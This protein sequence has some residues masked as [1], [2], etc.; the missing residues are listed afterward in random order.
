[1]ARL[2][3]LKISVFTAVF[4]VVALGLAL[5][6]A[7]GGSSNRSGTATVASVSAPAGN[8]SN[9]TAAAKS[10]ASNSS[11]TSVYNATHLGVVSI[12]STSNND[13][14][15]GGGFGGGG[16]RQST[17][18][19]SGILLDNKGDILT[20]EH[21]VDKATK[22][23]VSFDTTPNTTRTA[24]VVGTDPSTDLAVVK[25]DPT[26]LDLKPLTLGD[27]ST[28]QIG[29]TVYALGNPFGYTNSFS[30][31]IVSGLGRSITSPN[32]FGID[33]AIQ[34]DASINPGNSGGPLLDANGEVIG[35]NAQI[36]TGGQTAAGGEAG[37]NGVGFAIPINTAK[38]IAAQL[39][40]SGHV[41]HAYL[42]VAAASV[43]GS[44]QGSLTGAQSGALIQNVQ[45]G[46]PAAKAGIKAGTKRQVVD[47]AN[48]LLGGDV[49]QAIGGTKVTSS[50]DLAS[51]VSN[52]KPGDKVSVQL[53]RG[54]K[55]VTVQVTL[56]T[57]PS[58]APTG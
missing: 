53:V 28:A 16:S 29:D 48:V 31:G 4:A 52:L 45:A 10:V 22:V 40:Q 57:Q 21:V 6:L 51:A 19:G 33:N 24:T 36:A 35:V 37:N 55:Q 23:T 58:Q 11:A 17:A 54:G 50:N 56:G 34:T 7:T 12:L 49:V 9:S 1:M 46:S 5:V 26:G 27:S 41:S 3:N 42:G 43:A 2:L 25:V 44:L 15:G 20:N 18:L 13:S 32:G 30:E 39:E 14:S 8:S 38:G 47:G